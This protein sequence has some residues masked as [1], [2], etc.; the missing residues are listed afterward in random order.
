MR[1]TVWSGRN[2]VQVENVPDPKIL[3]SRDAIVKITSTAICGSD[4]HLYDG[5]IPT[6]R[7]G[8]IL[9]HEFM[10]EIVETGREVSNLKVGD[11][12]VV[13]FPI[14]CGACNAC[15]R[16]LFSLCENS[17]P[18]ASMAEKMFGDATAGIFGYSHLT[19]GYAGG[20][21][22][23]AR[24][25]FAD[26]GPIKIEGDFTDEQVL[27][28]SDIFPTGWMGAEMCD[29]KPGDI[30]AVWGC[31]PVGQFAIASAYLLGAER[32][33]AIDRF[34]YRLQM[35]REKGGAEI[36]NYERESVRE[37]LREMTGGRG[38]DACIDAVG[39]E[40]HHHNPGM[41]AYDRVKQAARLETE[42]GYALR[43]AIFNCRNGGIIS[44][45]GVY[46]GFMDKF[47][48]GAVMNRGLS[49]KT[50]Q[51]HVQRYLRPLL[52]RVEKGDIDPSFVVTH[53]MSLDDAPTGY[54][55]FK[56]KRDE[57]VKVVLK[58]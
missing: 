23:Y 40:A 4:L 21:A 13:P 34:D 2:K 14:A 57:C 30:I 46:G 17:N 5:Y 25:P 45:I 52:E 32:V 1:A 33:I 51:C 58:P 20:Q 22:E 19:G 9:G 39:M 37:A 7:K 42:R 48:I 10:G 6:M 54:E 56:N 53:R 44:M 35:A 29:I 15:E 47:P 50:G 24:V 31:G 38:P 16:Q 12:V 43:E 55:T 41:F 36:I 8:D 28:L 49:I 26:V 18:N 11:R 3:N 27:F